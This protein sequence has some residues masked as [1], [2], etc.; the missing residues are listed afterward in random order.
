MPKSH[1]YR[2][3]Q[4]TERLERVSGTNPVLFP[5]WKLTSART[6]LRSPDQGLIGFNPLEVPS[7]TWPL[8]VMRHGRVKDLTLDLKEWEWARAWHIK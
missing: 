4:N 8:Y 1:V 5:T 7:D 6:I 2:R 3:I